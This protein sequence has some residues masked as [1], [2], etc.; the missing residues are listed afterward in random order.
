MLRRLIGLLLMTALT[1]F[2]L[3]GCGEEPGEFNYSRSIDMVSREDGSGTRGAFIELLKIELLY[4][5]G[6][7]KDLTT[8][9]AIIATK[10]DVVLTNIAGDKYA[11]GYV[12]LGSL[13][14]TVKTLAV[15]EVPITAVNIKNG[16]YPIARSFN[17]V[18]K[19]EP[20]GLTKDFIDFIL[21]SDGQA[22]VSNG[23][24]SV[25]DT[26]PAYSGGKTGGKI[27]VAGSSSVSPIM[28]KLKESYII[29]NPNANIEIQMSD[30]TAGVTGTIEGISHIGMLSR[31]LKESEK[32]L[33]ISTPIALDGIAIIVNQRNPV[34]S[35]TREQVRSIFIGEATIWSDVVP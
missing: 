16:T 18:T 27:V 9:E 33:L 29:K 19:G 6:N 8:K 13:N 30:S 3:S 14:Q 1:V 10:T 11:I 28:E 23:Y 35:L 32:E 4:E 21:S 31:E 7:R 2:A 34:N 17:I 20:T 12:S 25:D 26:R 5:N 24:V 22:V 15:D